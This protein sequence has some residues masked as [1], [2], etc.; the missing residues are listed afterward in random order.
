M[1]DIDPNG[2]KTVRSDPRWF[3]VLS[4][5]VYPDVERVIR[6]TDGY[7]VVEKLGTSGEVAEA[8]AESNDELGGP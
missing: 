3:I 2:Y 1:L 7:A 5:H 4:R 8:E 6:Q